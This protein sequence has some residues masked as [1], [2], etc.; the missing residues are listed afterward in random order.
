MFIADSYDTHG[1]LTIDL[2]K[3]NAN[4]LHP[5][6]NEVYFD[7]KEFILSGCDTFEFTYIIH[8]IS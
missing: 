4:G 3:L 8:Y 6:R 2:K 7:R 1:K 5:T